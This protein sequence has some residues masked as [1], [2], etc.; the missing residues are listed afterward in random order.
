MWGAGWG[1][2]PPPPPPSMAHMQGMQGM[3]HAQVGPLA[4]PTLLQVDWAT[5]AQQWIMQA[6]Q[7]PQQPPGPG[8]QNGQQ[9]VGQVQGGP[10]RPPPPRPPPR[11]P[12]LLAPGTGEEGGGEANM[13]LEEEEGG[14][15]GWG[16][17]GHLAILQSETSRE[18][19]EGS[20]LRWEEARVVRGFPW[21]VGLGEDLP[22]G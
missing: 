11:P 5:L 19:R 22:A 10:P 15:G 14:G 1:A 7:Q 8:Q 3:A 12:P 13:E 17:Q 6:Q 20:P 21:T 18:R 16:H 2:G 4:I 9:W